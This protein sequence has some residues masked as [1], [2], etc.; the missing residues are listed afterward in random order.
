MQEGHPAKGSGVNLRDRLRLLVIPAEDFPRK[1]TGR[2]RHLKASRTAI[3]L[4]LHP[5]LMLRGK[6]RNPPA[7][8]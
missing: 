1:Q 7:L 2:R 4:R 3:G 6:H 5:P 8:F